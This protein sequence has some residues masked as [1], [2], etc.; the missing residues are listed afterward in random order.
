LWLEALSPNYLHHAE[1]SPLLSN[2]KDSYVYLIFD[3]IS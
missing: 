3:C 1:I 2:T